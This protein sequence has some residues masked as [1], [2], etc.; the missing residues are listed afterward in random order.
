M[1]YEGISFELSS[2]EGPYLRTLTEL[3]GV[4]SDDRSS[5]LVKV[6]ALAASNANIMDFADRVAELQVMASTLSA[7]AVIPA[8]SGP[9]VYSGDR[10]DSA[11]THLTRGMKV[12]VFTKGGARFSGQFEEYVAGRVWLSGETRR[13]VL[14]KD[15]LAVE[16]SRL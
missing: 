2:V 14:R 11:L 10:V 5:T 9:G 7:V 15:I 6:R 3:L 16:S 12:T 8:P 13:S 4:N 1:G